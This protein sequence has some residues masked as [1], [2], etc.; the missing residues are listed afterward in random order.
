MAQALKTLPPAASVR[1]SAPMAERLF[2]SLDGRDLVVGGQ[3]WHIE[4]YGICED[5]GRR[6]VQMASDG[7]QHHMLTLVLATRAGVHQ[8]V[9]TVTRWL[10][11]PS[12]S[13]QILSVV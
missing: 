5:A 2:A 12:D 6:W 11:E 9:A 8:A 7:P 10:D 13:P 4:V 3:A 1:R